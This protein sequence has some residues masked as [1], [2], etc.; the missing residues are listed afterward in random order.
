MKKTILIV[1]MSLFFMVGCTNV[2]LQE[3]EPEVDKSIS[4]DKT[5]D[6]SGIEK[7][8][9]ETPDGVV[10]FLTEELGGLN[11]VT[12]NSL[13]EDIVLIT[14]C[15]DDCLEYKYKI[16]DLKNQKLIRELKGGMRGEYDVY[17]Y[18]NYIVLQNKLN[19]V[20]IL[21]KDYSHNTEFTVDRKLMT[22]HT[23]FC[24]S[25]SNQKVYFISYDGEDDTASAFLYSVDYSGDDIELLLTMHD[26]GEEVFDFSKMMCSYD[27]KELYYIGDYFPN[28]DKD[29]QSEYC[30]GTFGLESK[31]LSMQKAP[32]YYKLAQGVC[33]GLWGI[34]LDNQGDT[35]DG[36]MYY[37]PLNGEMTFVTIK[38]HEDYDWVLEFFYR[39]EPVALTL[40][41]SED[42]TTGAL[43]GCDI[44]VYNLNTG[45][46]IGSAHTE[47]VLYE[48]E[49]CY[50]SCLGGCLDINF[51][52]ETS[53]RKIIFTPINWS[54][55]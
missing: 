11:I 26:D 5:E 36:K 47:S 8:I 1:A 28:R 24:V 20:I 52:S 27:E 43:N 41:N 30:V 40:K 48:N 50:I 16:L 31:E 38:N 49:L 10:K 55:E 46:Y 14:M 18:E 51:N 45:K 4:F 29:S 2:K 25:P 44:D 53:E 32:N 54:N 34:G 19:Q 22:E 42:A 15:D 9:S 35:Y 13:D 37:K 7:K 21:N 3:G 33:G 17:R 39:E 23:P 12:M 6:V